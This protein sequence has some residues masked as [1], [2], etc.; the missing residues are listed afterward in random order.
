MLLRI[1]RST[2]DSW[3][4]ARFLSATA[5]IFG[6]ILVVLF[7][8][9]FFLLIIGERVRLWYL[10]QIREPRFFSPDPATGRQFLEFGKEDVLLAR[11]YG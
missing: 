7:F 11:K 4:R 8:L 2:F 6:I 1:F 9:L 3:L 10:S 5:V